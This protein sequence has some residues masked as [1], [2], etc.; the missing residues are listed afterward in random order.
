MRKHI[1]VLLSHHHHTLAC[2]DDGRL[3]V[4]LLSQPRNQDA[5]HQLRHLGS[6]IGHHLQKT[7]LSGSIQ[8]KVACDGWRG[9]Y[10]NGRG[11]W[12]L[13]TYSDKRD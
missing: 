5:L 7:S 13:R 4:A 9:V 3:I 6:K 1:D 10:G 8:E 12:L 11:G 2:V